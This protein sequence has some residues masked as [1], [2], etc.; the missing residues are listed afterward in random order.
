MVS[1]DCALCE[2]EGREERALCC[3]DERSCNN[4]QSAELVF[5]V[6]SSSLSLL[7]S[8]GAHSL[9]IPLY[10]SSPFSVMDMVEWTRKKRSSSETHS[11]TQKNFL[12]F[13]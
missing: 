6:P 4:D 11:I 3:T 5:S 9:L 10:C 12:C 2:G 8:R 13:Q 1:L 7:F